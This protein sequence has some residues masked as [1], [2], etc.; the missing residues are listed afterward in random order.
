MQQDP[1]LNNPESVPKPELTLEERKERCIELFKT[2]KEE[3]MK[4]LDQALNIVG[5]PAIDNFHVSIEIEEGEKKLDEFRSLLAR[6][7]VSKTL[8]GHEA[9]KDGDKALKDIAI[10]F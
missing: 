10:L 8:T 1:N 5:A 9:K 3:D 6:Y 2:L 4:R 7:K